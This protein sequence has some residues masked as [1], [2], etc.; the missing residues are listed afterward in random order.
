MR[1]QCNVCE[2]AEA[3]VLCCADEAALCWE[4]D[5]KVHAANKLASKHQRVPLSSSS[6]QM[7]KCDICQETSGFFFC[8]QD[9]ALL[10]RKCDVAIHTANSYVSAHQRFLL[11]GV[12]VGLEPADP[13]ASS[14]SIKS[15][16]GENILDMKS[17]SLSRRD[18]LMPVAA[19]CKEVLPASSG[20]VGDF[21]MNKVSFAGGSAAGSTPSWHMDDFLALPELNQNYSFMDNGSS[22]ADSGKRGDSDSSSILRSAEEELDDDECLG[23]VPEASW[24]VPQVPS[25]PT[26]SGLY[27]PKNP[28]NQ[29]DS[30]FVPDIHH[31]SQLNRTA[32]RR[33]L[34]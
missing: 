22:K 11:T 3:K 20:G 14:S 18:A 26:A 7:P 16:S 32:T 1:I 24:A 33:R 12:K 28:Q 15:L 29:Y 31:H 10:C 5:D 21:A 19:E 6:T 34:Q 9:R 2:A 4:C 23:Q 8:L 17:H 25:P 13:G 27:W 30:A